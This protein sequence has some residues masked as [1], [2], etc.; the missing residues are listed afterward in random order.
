MQNIR[1]S[2]VPHIAKNAQVAMRLL[3]SCNRLVQEADGW[4]CLHGLGQLVH[5]KSVLSTIVNRLVAS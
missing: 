4:V 2:R 3:T 5:D 1:L